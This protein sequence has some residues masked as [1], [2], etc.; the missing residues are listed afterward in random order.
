MQPHM[1]ADEMTRLTL[2]KAIEDTEHAL[3]GVCLPELKAVVGALLSAITPCSVRPRI[4]YAHS[5]GAST[6]S[7]TRKA[8]IIPTL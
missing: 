1:R 4:N 3:I 6:M 5:K 8:P 7:L 2:T